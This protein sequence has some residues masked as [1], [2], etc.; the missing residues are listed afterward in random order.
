MNISNSDKFGRESFGAVK[1]PKLKGHVKITL[2]NVMNHKTEVIEGDNVVTNYLG[3]VLANNYLSGLNLSSMLPLAD[4]WFGGV[5]AFRNAF[6]TVTIDGNVVPDPS[7]YY[8]EGDDVNPL[9]AH[10]GDTAPATASIVAQDYKRG[11]PV[12]VTKTSNSIKFGWQWLPSQG[13]GIINAIS[14]T[15]V[16]TGNAG[17]GNTSDAFKALQPFASI[18]SLAD[19]SIGVTSD[20]NAFCQ[21]DD[22][23]SLWFHIG[24]VSDFYYEHTTFQTH[25]LTIVI[26]RL[27]YK[28][29]GLHELI[30]AEP[31]YPTTF[32]ITLSGFYLY[33]QPSYY[34]DYTNKKL[35]I[36][37]NTT[38]VYGYH[39][40][41]YSRNT[42]NYAVIDCVG[43]TIETEGTIVSN[44]NDLAPMSMEK[45]CNSSFR[46]SPSVMRN[47]NII[48][49]GNKVFLPMSDGASSGEGTADISRFNVK[50]LKVI[51][52]TDQGGTQ[53]VISY[54]EV[55]EQ[56]KSSIKC[57][58][59]ILN[60][61]RVVNGGVGYTCASQLSEAESIPCYAF[62]EPDNASSV[63][64]YLG[65]GSSVGNQPRFILAPKLALTTKYNVNQVEKTGVQAMTIEY[66]L[67][68]Q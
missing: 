12:S 5:L 41:K 21:Y 31:D 56:F 25:D 28:K 51:D 66:T 60:S 16:D 45:F 55:Q 42:V 50:G 59:L 3:D 10:A 46:Y 11:S 57:G 37:S 38:G 13:C 22:N 35:W 52:I 36:F 26:R 39:D 27:P 49:E 54:N 44:D 4:K 32:T 17:I 14:L 7:K 53:D 34:F 65:A 2:H 24:G 58:G 9:I 62:H 29:V 47:A 19:A 8:P 20:N 48:K 33:D 18:G 63:A 43:Q 64:T 40:P 67:T 15:H 23:H 30:V 1:F 61:G 68:E 6:S